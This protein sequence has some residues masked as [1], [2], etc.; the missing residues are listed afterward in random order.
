[1]KCFYHLE[2]EATGECALC[3]K[4]LCESCIESSSG[5]GLCRKCGAFSG[6]RRREISPASGV[7]SIFLPGLGQLIRGEFVKAAAIF[8]LFIYAMSQE[9]FAAGMLVYVFGVWDG[10]RM[11]IT[12]DELGLSARN[13]RVYAGVLL[14]AFG[15]SLLPGPLREFAGFE[16]L[17]PGILFV[18]GLYLVSTRKAAGNAGN[19]SSVPDASGADRS[20]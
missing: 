3:G 5:G 1:M 18:F 7:T 10:F 15:V 12:E 17:V 20:V 14:I 2:A 8:M 6:G 19:K 11:L 16:W 9:L 13:G 4:P